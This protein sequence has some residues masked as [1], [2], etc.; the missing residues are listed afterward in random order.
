LRPTMLRYVALACCDRL[1]G[2]SQIKFKLI[3]KKV[4]S[5]GNYGTKIGRNFLMAF[6]SSVTTIKEPLSRDQFNMIRRFPEL[7]G[8]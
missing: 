4:E 3:N 5:R 8:F 2:A 6:Q 1:A 7:S